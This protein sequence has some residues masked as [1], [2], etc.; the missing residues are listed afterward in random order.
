MC[1][2]KNF[3]NGQNMTFKK[4]NVIAYLKKFIQD[5]NDGDYM[6]IDFYK[7]NNDGKYEP[8]MEEQDIEIYT[9]ET[10]RN[11]TRNVE[12]YIKSFI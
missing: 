4:Y 2:I 12:G 10:V 11:F 6:I 1:I 9:N 5:E 3:P 8:I 7:M